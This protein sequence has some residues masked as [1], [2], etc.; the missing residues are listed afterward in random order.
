[1]IVRGIR[2]DLI[3]VIFMQYKNVRYNL[4][5]FK[6]VFYGDICVDFSCDVVIHGKVFTHVLDSGRLLFGLHMI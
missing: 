6:R 1:M 5:L 4:L 3:F 2:K